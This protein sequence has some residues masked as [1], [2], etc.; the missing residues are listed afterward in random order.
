MDEKLQESVKKLL[1]LEVYVILSQ[2]GISL[3]LRGDFS[4]QGQGYYKV[5]Y[6]KEDASVIFHE[7]N[8]IA[9][10]YPDKKICIRFGE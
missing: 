7:S 2:N 1:G 10:V 6:I 8:I 4:Y 5:K 9:A 3:T